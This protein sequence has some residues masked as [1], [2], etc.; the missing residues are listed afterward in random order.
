MLLVIDNYDSF[1]WNLVQYFG[2]LGAEPVVRR[3][4]ELT[5]EEIEAL[6]PEVPVPT[7]LADR[8]STRWLR[9]RAS[10]VMVRD[11]VGGI[12]TH[13][14]PLTEYRYAVTAEPPLSEGGAS[15][16]TAVP[17]DATTEVI[18]GGCGT[19]SGTTLTGSEAGP[20][21]AAFTARSRTW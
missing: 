6:A 4:D 15:P 3:N 18:R 2:T 13:G 7:E 8:T 17:P 12:D 10:P 16:I 19:V 11:S 9:P 20:G 1:T 5:V 21:P 14:P